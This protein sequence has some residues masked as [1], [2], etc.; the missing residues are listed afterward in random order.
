MST[1][2]VKKLTEKIDFNK[3]FLK[4]YNGLLLTEEQ[5]EILKKYGIDY[6]NCGSTS[7]L[8]YI[9][10]QI[11]ENNDFYELEMIADILQERNYYEYTNK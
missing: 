6:E 3:N 2:D 10:D 4:N 7:E 11:L 1:E 8:I 5:V 9:I